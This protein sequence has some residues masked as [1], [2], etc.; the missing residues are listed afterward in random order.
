MA[1]RV[2]KEAL[3]DKSGQGHKTW[4]ERQVRVHLVGAGLS[5]ISEPMSEKEAHAWASR[6]TRTFPGLSF[7]IV[8][9]TESAGIADEQSDSRAQR[10]SSTPCDS[11]G[12]GASERENV[13]RPHLNL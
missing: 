1:R 5:G 8:S 4:P 10:T 2:S 11:I 13:L 3:R 7:Q 9:T 6:A 12:T